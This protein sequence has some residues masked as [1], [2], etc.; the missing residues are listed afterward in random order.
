MTRRAPCDPKRP[1]P[2]RRE[3][4]RPARLSEPRRELAEVAAA[5]GRGPPAAPRRAAPTWAHSAPIAPLRRAS[6]AARPLRP[7]ASAGA[8]HVCC[9]VPGGAVAASEKSRF[10]VGAG[11][12]GGRGLADGADG[13]GAGTAAAA[14]TGAG[15]WTAAVTVGA[16][17]PPRAGLR[18]GRRPG[19]RGGRERRRRS[20]AQASGAPP[21]HASCAWIWRSPGAICSVFWYC[22]WAPRRSPSASRACA[23]EAARQD[24]VRRFPQGRS[25]APRAL[26]SR[27]P[28]RAA[29]GPESAVPKGSPGGRPGPRAPPGSPRRARL[30]CAAPRRA[31]RRAGS[32]GSRSRRR[33]SS[34][35]RVSATVSSGPR[36]DRHAPPGRR[37][38]FTAGRSRSAEPGRVP[39]PV[40]R[41]PT[42]IVVFSVPATR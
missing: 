21:G 17:P 16:S 20:R 18:R 37:P 31:A 12:A 38:C 36:R 30:P 4:R 27:R 28:S 1:R 33:R 15:S 13:A 22:S 23:Q 24:V 3:R 32:P 10:G 5:G 39:E 40:T 35:M 11:G 19:R 2:G 6:A 9:T 34:S 7:A 8:N 26:R 25:P 14:A 41:T 29:R 42:T